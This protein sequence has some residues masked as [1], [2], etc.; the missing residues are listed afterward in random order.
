MSTRERQV[1]KW[2]AKLRNLINY[3]RE[4]NWLEIEVG[5]SWVVLGG[6]SGST[7][8]WDC[9][10]YQSRWYFRNR[11]LFKV[12]LIQEFLLS[13]SF[14][15]RLVCSFK[16]KIPLYG[17]LAGKLKV[18]SLRSFCEV[19]VRV[20]KRTWW[21]CFYNTDIF[22]CKT[23]FVFK[24]YLWLSHKLALEKTVTLRIQNITINLQI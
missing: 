22:T 11:C 7:E 23:E 12:V 4:G 6:L 20:M 10:K 17:R 21:K 2:S 9:Q 16:Q 8:N 13:S 5:I 24:L 14:V 18:L 1:C 15:N 3:V 19:T